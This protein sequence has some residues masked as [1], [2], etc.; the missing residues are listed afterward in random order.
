MPNDN[1]CLDC[2]KDPIGNGGARG[3]CKSCYYKRRR[4]G[5]LTELPTRNRSFEEHLAAIVPNE[6]D[7]WPWP[8]FVNQGGYG[9]TGRHTQAHVA[10]HRHH[11]GPV[12]RKHDVGHICHDKDP[13]CQDWRTCQHRRCVNPEHLV[14]QTRSEN[15]LARPY[16]QTHCK[17]GHEL[18]L[19]NVHVIPQTGSRQCLPCERLVRAEYRDRRNALRRAK[20]RQRGEL[21]DQA[22]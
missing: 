12:P 6:N 20:T 22:C 1:C 9:M 15:L 13:D 18:T 16:K 19:E 21:R 7:C 11:I 2:G 14:A 3:L 10:S 5:L 17:R 8:G 4:R